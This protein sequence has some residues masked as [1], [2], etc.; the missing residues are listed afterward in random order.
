MKRK[1]N[2]IAV[3]LL[4]I[5]AALTRLMPHWPN[6][7]PI[8]AMGLLAGATVKDKKLAYIIPLAALFLSDVC[9]QVFTAIPLPWKFVGF[10]SW[11][12]LFTYGAFIIIV[13]MGTFIHKIR[14]RSVVASSVLASVVFFLITNF[15]VWLLGDMYPKSGG[16]LVSCY[17]AGIPF[18]GNTVIGDLFYCGML[19]GGYYL[20]THYVIKR[21]G[22]FSE[23]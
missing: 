6:F 21:Q 5:A 2:L 12:Q 4:I 19:F 9:L 16:G 20:I 15:S 14:F 3:S 7:T 22:A 11:G 13:F 8:A 10:Y 18:F 23:A 1:S 17:V